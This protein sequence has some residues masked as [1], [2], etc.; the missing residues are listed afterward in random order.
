[1]ACSYSNEECSYE[2]TVAV[3]TSFLDAVRQKYCDDDEVENLPTVQQGLL[4][5]IVF[6]GKPKDSSHGKAE[7]GFLRNVV[8]LT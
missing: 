2:S 4:I 1:M 5:D 6:H 3:Q 8:S 7:L